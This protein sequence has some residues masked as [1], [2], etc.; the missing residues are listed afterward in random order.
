VKGEQLSSTMPARQYFFRSRQFSYA[1]KVLKVFAIF[2]GVGR[3][4][5]NPQIT[6]MDRLKN[7]PGQAHFIDLC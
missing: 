6:Q 5:E 1:G 3:R 2:L 4:Q 7:Q